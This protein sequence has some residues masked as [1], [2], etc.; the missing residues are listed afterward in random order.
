MVAWVTGA[1]SVAQASP[2]GAKRLAV[3]EL[4]AGPE[5]SADARA[6]LTDVVRGASLRL[7]RAQWFVLTRENILQSL[8]PGTELSACEGDCEVE[9]GRNVGAHVVISGELVRLGG[10]V[11]ITLKA[12]ETEK[13]RLLASSRA[14]AKTVDTLEVPLERAAASI[15]RGLPGGHRLRDPETRDT[16]G[17]RLAELSR[18][19]AARRA[20]E[21]AEEALRAEALEA[22]RKTLEAQWRQV[23][24]LG[25]AG[26]PE[27]RQAVKLF[28]KQYA[29][30]PLGNHRAMEAKAL[31]ARM[32]G[33][34][35]VEEAGKGGV[36]W[37]TIPGG[38][39]S[40][41]RSDGQLDERP[42]HAVSIASFQLARTET[43]V[44]QYQACVDEGACTLPGTDPADPHPLPEGCAFQ[45]AGQADWPMDCVTLAESRDFAR[46]VGGRLPS[47][48]EWAYAARGA[49]GK[50]P[51]GAAAL[52]VAGPVCSTPQN[53][54]GLCDMSGNAWERVLGAYTSSYTGAPT[55]QQPWWPDA[56]GA[57]DRGPLRPVRL[58]YT[59]MPRL[60]QK[61]YVLQPIE[62]PAAMPDGFAERVRVHFKSLAFAKKATYGRTRLGFKADA[63]KTGEVYVY[64]DP[65]KAS[66]HPIVMAE[67]FHTFIAAGARRVFFPGVVDTG[68]RAGAAHVP[69]P[70]YVPQW[71]PALRRWRT[72]LSEG[73]WPDRHNLLGL[74]RGGAIGTSEASQRQITYR[75]PEGPRDRVVGLGFRVA[76]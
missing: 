2:E 18:L 39:F 38:R 5:F 70:I 46:W 12:H 35:G 13:G 49:G 59:A 58:S 34:Q 66:F 72:E 63:A 17:D 67:V 48:A 16:M 27:G 23:A 29:D 3:L 22:H 52:S 4:K 21:A 9:T 25:R 7:P 28:L 15:L 47:E 60:G 41:G 65:R 36:V 68:W 20:A 73:L 19:Q 24:P 43:T 10:A 62:I 37:L 11:R 51:P 33:G 45:Q 55:D 6:Y 54:L 71:T 1:V 61:R 50:I 42:V 56:G 30:H 76:R 57:I 31:L 74:S 69:Y 40:M 26:G 44:G 75:N 32:L 53:P 14:S 64:L 8:P